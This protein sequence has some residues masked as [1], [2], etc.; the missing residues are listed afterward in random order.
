MPKPNHCRHVMYHYAFSAS[1]AEIPQKKRELKLQCADE[2]D[3]SFDP[4]IMGL[5]PRFMYIHQ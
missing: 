3:V 2:M 4:R 5:S 1:K